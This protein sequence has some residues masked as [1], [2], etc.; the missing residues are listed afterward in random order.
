MKII[1]FIIVFVWY[2]SRC[3][4]RSF[5]VSMQPED[6]SFYQHCRL[7]SLIILYSYQHLS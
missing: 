2:L 4:L 3:C 1:S 5:G 6:E 7:G